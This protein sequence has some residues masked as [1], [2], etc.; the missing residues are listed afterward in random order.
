M[1]RPPRRGRRGWIVN[2]LAM[3][4]VLLASI[5]A[6]VA[7]KPFEAA[8]IGGLIGVFIGLG[9]LAFP[10]LDRGGPADHDDMMH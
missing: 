1:A 4:S 2:A 3:P 7:D 5:F 8:I 10:D 9:I 6:L